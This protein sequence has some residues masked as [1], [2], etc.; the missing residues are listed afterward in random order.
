MILVAA[1]IIKALGAPQ[2]PAARTRGRY[3]FHLLIL[4]LVV[5]VAG[6]MELHTRLKWKAIVPLYCLVS[7]IRL[8]G[9]LSYEA[10][11]YASK[12]KNINDLE[13]A[14]AHWI[15]RETGEDAR[16]ATNDIGAIAFFGNRFIVDTEG[17]VTP[18]AIHPKRMRRF[19][20]FLESQRP[21][22]LVIFPE[23]YPRSRPGRTC[24]TRS[25]ASTRTRIRG[26]AA[27][28]HLS[29]AMDAQ[30]CRAPLRAVM[31]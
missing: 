30:R 9:A 26:R 2:P 29:N 27:P 7:L 4:F 13:V 8:G 20:P 25:I 23:W 12:V 6:L 11:R 3:L 10:P 28:G 22:L 31:R 15:Q 1:P 24:S 17:L 5:A 19:V 14:T 18:E 16:I 21:D